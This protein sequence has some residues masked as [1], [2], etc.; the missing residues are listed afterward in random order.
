MFYGFGDTAS[1]ASATQPSQAFIAAH[2]AYRA[3]HTADPVLAAQLLKE[4]TASA[5]AYK[6]AQGGPALPTWALLAG[7]IAAIFLLTR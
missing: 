3:S 6:A 1:T 4:D 2:P 7:G 5:Q